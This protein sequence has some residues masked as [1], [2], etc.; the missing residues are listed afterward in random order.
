MSR[1]G[2]DHAAGTR[3][4]MISRYRWVIANTLAVTEMTSWGILYYGFAVM[5]IPMQQELGWSTETFTGAFSLAL[6]VSGFVSI[7]IGRALDRFSPR[8]IM[9]IGSAVAILCVVAWSHVRTPEQLYAVWLV[10]G[11]VM[12]AV[13]YDPAFAVIAKWFTHSRKTALTVVTFGGGLA[14]VVYVPFATWLTTVTGWRMALLIMA[15]ILAVGTLLPHLLFLRHTPVH[16]ETLPSQGGNEHSPAR[17]KHVLRE[18]SFWWITAAFSLVSYVSVALSVHL[19]PYL[20]QQ[21]FERETAAFMVSI[22]GGSQIIGRLA[23][24]PLGERVPQRLLLVALLGLAV[25]ALF[26]L[27]LFPTYMGVFTF[28]I[29]LGSGYGAS[30]PA[31]ASLLADIYGSAHYGEINGAMTLIATVARAIA[32]L[33]VGVLLGLSGSYSVVLMLLTLFA[34]GAV[35]SISRVL[36]PG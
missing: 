18:A 24:A 13:L 32:P 29:L 14:S 21:N 17:L 35:F 3:L 8:L 23:L 12:A 22:L 20:A 31:R 7:P 2:S 6:L 26:I 15:I 9:S 25:L 30:S 5:L 10:I 36:T 27:I 33:S 4:A 11:I 34:I 28:A 1:F 16:D 19:M